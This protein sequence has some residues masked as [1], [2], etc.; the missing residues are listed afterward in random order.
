MACHRLAPARCPKDTSKTDQSC[1]AGA[2]ADRRERSRSV[3]RSVCGRSSSRAARSRHGCGAQAAA[4]THRGVLYP[5]L[6]MHRGR[7]LELQRE[8]DRLDRGTSGRG[9]ID[10]ACLP[11]PCRAQLGLEARAGEVRRRGI[12]QRAKQ[13]H[14]LGR[15]EPGSHLA[16]QVLDAAQSAALLARERDRAHVIA[17]RS[18]VVQLRVAR[19]AQLPRVARR[20]QAHGRA[21]ARAWQRWCTPALLLGHSRAARRAAGRSVASADRA[22]A[23]RHLLDAPC[24]TRCCSREWQQS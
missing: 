23:A 21:L 17:V 14:L 5:S 18:D 11:R 24:T 13:R 10:V 8:V 2:D 7:E 9:R 16:E 4:K 15:A 19:F 12:M 20:G 6:L 1:A 3:P 22:G